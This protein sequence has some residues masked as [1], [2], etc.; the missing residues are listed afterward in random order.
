LE[1]TGTI[2]VGKRADLVLLTGNPLQ[3]IQHTARS[4]GVMI[5][6]RWLSREVIDQRLGEIE[7]E[8]QATISKMV[9]ENRK[10]REESKKRRD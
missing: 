10:R 4:A 5:G 6:G 9:A 3:D 8:R 2:A 7:T 1:E